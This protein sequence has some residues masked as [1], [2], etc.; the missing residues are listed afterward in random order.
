VKVAYFSPM[1]PETSG[2]ADYSALLLPE[3]R[4][5]LDVTV[6]ARGAKPPPRGTDLAR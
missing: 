4:Q 6:V 5:R 1:P 2:I 3:L